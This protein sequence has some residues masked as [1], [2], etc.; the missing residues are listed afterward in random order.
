MLNRRSFLHSSLAAGLSFLA[1]VE[2]SADI[3]LS[4]Y[5]RALANPGTWKYLGRPHS[6]S[7]VRQGFH[8][9]VPDRVIIMTEEGGWLQGTGSHLRELWQGPLSAEKF[10]WIVRISQVLTEHYHIPLEGW[11]KGLA[12]REALGSTAMGQGFGLVHQFQDDQQI[13]LE[14][15]P[16]DW[17]LFL[18]PNGIEWDACDDEPV[19]GMIGHVFSADHMNHAGLKLRPYVLTTAIAWSVIMDDGWKSIA[20]MDGTTAARKVN[21]AVARRIA[22]PPFSILGAAQPTI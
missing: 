8:P 13:R 10:A 4:D 14:N 12:R 18:F 3:V 9:I 22:E 1:P 11:V 21:S 20:R 16:V 2:A 5:E 7:L 6:W 19:Y 17:W 15:A